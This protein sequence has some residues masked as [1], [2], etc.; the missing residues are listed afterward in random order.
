LCRPDWRPAVRILGYSI[1]KDLQTNGFGDEESNLDEQG[2]S[3]PAC[4]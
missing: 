1:V 3:L 4:H 2:Q